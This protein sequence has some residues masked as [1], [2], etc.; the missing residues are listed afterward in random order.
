MPEDYSLHASARASESPIYCLSDKVLS[1]HD[2]DASAGNVKTEVP[3]QPPSKVGRQA[4]EKADFQVH[5]PD[6]ALLAT[7]QGLQ[8][9][10]GV[11]IHHLRRLALKELA[12]N[13]LDAADAAD[14]PGQVRIERI[15]D[16]VYAVEDQGN[17]LPGNQDEIAN[18]FSLGREMISR[19]FWRLP[20]RGC[21]GN[22]LRIIVGT[23]AATGGTIEITTLNRRML[24]RPLKSGKTEIVSTRNGGTSDWD[25]TGRDLWRGAAPRRSRPVLGAVGNSA[26]AEGGADILACR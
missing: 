12:D 8:M 23:V 10:S 3:A 5:R 18:L 17:G 1:S 16:Q 25:T 24:L 14:R 20:S 11:P 21:L 4:P 13:A 15:T 7:L 19:K 22:G 9:Q 2:D 6:T 26:R